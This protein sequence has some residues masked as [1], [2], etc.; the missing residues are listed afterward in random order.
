[1]KKINS[2]IKKLA[3]AS[4]LLFA[5]ATVF[6]QG[7]I[8]LTPNSRGVQISESSFEGF[9]STFSFDKIEGTAMKTEKGEFSVI[10]MGKTINAGELGAPSLPIA[11]ELIAVPFGATPVVKV[12]SYSTQDYNL[13][14]YGINK[15]YPQQPSYSKS[16]KVEDM[17]F[18]YNEKAYQTR[19]LTN[20]PEVI[21]EV[22]GTMR[23]IQ[24]GALQIEPVSYNPANNTLRVYNDIQV[25]VTFENAD[26]A[27]TEQ[28]LVNTYSPYFDVIYK[29]LFNSR[30]IEDVYDDHPDIFSSPVRMLVIANRMFEDA[31]Q[32]WL[33]WKTKKG[34]YLTV[35]YTDE[36]SNATATGIT[37]Y[38]TEQYNTDTP[39]TFVIVF[40]DEEQ[41]VPSKDSGVDSG[42]VTDLY[43]SSV[44]GDY[45]PDIYHSRM[46]CETV[47]EMEALIHKI[48]QYEQY[49][50]PDPSYL[51]N[52]LLI[53][54]VDGYWN[55]IVGQ[56]TIEYAS[57]Y[58]FNEEHGYENV[59]KYLNSYS[60][61][62][63][64]LSTGV[65]FANYTA[66]GSETSWADP[67]F[68]V[69]NANNLTNTDKYFWA[70]GNC[71]NAA[72]WGYGSVCLGEAMIRGNQKGAWSYIGSCP[73]SYWWEDY[74]FGVGATNVTNRMPL[75]EETSM[76]NYDAHFMEDT[77]NPI[78]AVPFAGNLAVAY[79]HDNNYEGSATTRYYFEAYHVLGD[80][81]VM[82]YRS[83]PSDNDVSHLPTL[84]IGMDF[85]TVAA[86]PGSYVGISKDGVLYGAGMV[87]D[88]GSEDIEMTPIT[89]GGDVTIVVTHPNRI[90]YV[91]TIPAA[92]MDGA[93]LSVAEYTPSQIAV[94]EET[95]LSLSVK[96]VG[97]DAT[98]SGGTITLSCEE[99]FVT[100]TDAEGS[101]SAIAVDGVVELENEFKLNVEEGVA[102]GTK[103]NV[104]YTI[105]SGSDSWEGRFSME[106]IAPKMEFKDFSWAGMYE[107]GETY[108]VVAKFENRGAYKA[109]N[110]K[111]VASST[112]QYLTIAEDTFEFG[113]IDPN[114]VGIFSFDV[115]VGE[116]CPTTEVLE[117]N[118][119]LTADNGVTAEGVGYLRNT[120]LVDFVMQDSYGDGWNGSTLVLTFDNGDPSV[121][122]A[123]DGGEEKIHTLEIGTGIKTTVSFSANGNYWTYE[124]SYLIKYHEGDEIYNSNGEPNEG[125][126]TDF[127]VSCAGEGGATL[128]PV[129][130]LEAQVELNQVTL[131]WDAPRAFSNYAIERN[132]VQVAE[133]EET[134]FV[135]SELAD[136]TYTYSVTAV[137]EEGA[138]MPVSVTVI[139]GD[140]NV[141]ENESLM[142]VVYPNPANDVI[143]IN[144]N[145]SEYEYQLI[146]ALGQV[147][148]SGQ[149]SGKHQLD[150]T[151]INKGVYFL[152]VIANGETSINKVLVQ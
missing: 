92:A 65:G 28:T 11:R 57:H 21:F 125:Y 39:P 132:G 37:Q 151:N 86:A 5:G 9:Q 70:M 20:A 75:Y 144:S 48:L 93:Y 152:K 102:N 51:D 58:Y 142:F 91:E 147:V 148:V 146:N 8:E 101:F 103:F 118:F 109:T 72:D 110:A 40:G 106:V 121:S 69:S 78:A 88:S 52:V 47:A 7:Q 85:F 81:S 99:D 18:Q 27:L 94:N 123:F 134:T 26:L 127:V 116:S 44:D 54:G 46:C 113:T 77:Y 115:T 128:N 95:T 96:N 36:L 63:N 64:N 89:S 114:G 33:E 50:M 22:L 139:V 45:F 129:Q 107:A 108:T 136:G 19:A 60:G 150:I 122:L 30:A 83:M 104:F 73:V 31:M 12:V 16:T 55:P 13:S 34:F 100:F 35:K 97:A 145:A 90:P 1:M 14:D 74:Y 124:C 4:L 32:P 119:E 79:S 42:R 61:C 15:V 25:E 23:G 68:T 98:T 62:Y 41:V 80:A 6:A 105:T 120:C 117:I 112:S 49:T 149:S 84:P 53:A 24:L 43:Y 82:P 59:Y 66:H 138:S 38:V 133:T 10:T 29:Q 111:V 87:G 130:D 140:D 137:Y 135:D 141:M 3:L 67:S 76:G 143:N 2:L 56:P 131:T 17:V 71:C 126:N